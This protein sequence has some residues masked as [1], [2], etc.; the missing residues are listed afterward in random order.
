VAARV[1][2]WAEA[3]GSKR[4]STDDYVV[5]LIPRARGIT[6]PDMARALT[7]RDRAMQARSRAV[8]NEA[9]ES[10]QP[11]AKALGAI[12]ENPERRARWV[13]EILTVAAYRDRWHIHGL[14]SIGTSSRAMAQ[15]QAARRG[16]R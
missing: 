11:W 13:H 4:R 14:R 7:E 6:D 15:F 12:P 16:C 5:G 10:G 1:D 8:A 9:L 2:R 3:A